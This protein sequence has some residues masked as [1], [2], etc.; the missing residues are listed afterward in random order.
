[1]IR[2]VLSYWSKKIVIIWSENFLFE[3]FLLL[4]KMA[5]GLYLSVMNRD[6]LI[7]VIGLFDLIRTY[8]LYCNKINNYY[9]YYLKNTY[10]VNKK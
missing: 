4:R 3:T 5:L 2:V 1:M 9:K 7:D 8:N 10:S 6:Q